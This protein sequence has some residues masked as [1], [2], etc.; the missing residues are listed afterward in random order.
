[1]V[2]WIIEASHINIV[3]FYLSNMEHRRKISIGIRQP[4][5]NLMFS[6]FLIIRLI[7]HEKSLLKLLLKD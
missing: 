6:Y 4:V 5:W 1:V 2:T 7:I 3:L